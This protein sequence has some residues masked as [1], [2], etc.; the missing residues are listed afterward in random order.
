MDSSRYLSPSGLSR[1]AGCRCLVQPLGTGT[2]TLRQIMD[3]KMDSACNDPH[4]ERGEL[5]DVRR[6]LL[7]DEVLGIMDQLLCH[8]VRPLSSRCANVR[9][10]RL[11]D[12]LLDGVASRLP[13]IPDSFH[14]R[15]R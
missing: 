2:D 9:E 4:N 1:Y 8:E 13:T 15:V 5:Y 7:P 12:D 10:T 6:E 3:P 11:A 14:E